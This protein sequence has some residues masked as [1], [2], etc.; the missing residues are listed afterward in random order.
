MTGL[1]RSPITVVWA[2]LI[3]ATS[4]SWVLGTQS[5]EESTGAGVAVMLVAFLKIR[6]VGLYFMELRHAPVTLRGIFEGY[7]LV[8]AAA[9]IGLYLAA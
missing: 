9:V 2:G 4:V 5:A 6:F 8:V 7:V 1:L 3:L